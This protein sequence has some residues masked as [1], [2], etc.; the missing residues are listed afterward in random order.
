MAELTG[1]CTA[2]GNCICN[3]GDHHP[4]DTNSR[5]HVMDN[6]DLL[7]RQGLDCNQAEKISPKVYYGVW[8]SL[9]QLL[10]LPRIWILFWCAYDNYCS[11]YEIFVPADEVA[12]VHSVGQHLSIHPHV[13]MSFHLVRFP[14]I[15]SRMHGRNGLK[16]GMQKQRFKIIDFLMGPWDPPAM[17]HMGHGTLGMGPI[18]DVFI[19]GK[20]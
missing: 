16:F 5:C 6:H 9:V 7:C 4:Y 13:R 17:I 18:I 12:C 2:S 8:S 15:L 19:N 11:F 1:Q 10:A 14:S 20:F 3:E